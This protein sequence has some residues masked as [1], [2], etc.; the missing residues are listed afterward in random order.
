MATILHTSPVTGM[1]ID[2]AAI[3]FDVFVQSRSGSQCVAVHVVDDL[4][5]DVGVGAVNAQTWTA[6]SD[7]FQT[8]AYAGSTTLLGR[9]FVCHD[10]LLLL[11]FFAE[12]NFVRVFDALAFVGLRWTVCANF[13]SNLTNNLLVM[14]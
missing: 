5:V 3:A 2:V 6:A 10:V 13:S 7:L 12:D 8:A 11:A 9:K 1:S 4:G 14:T